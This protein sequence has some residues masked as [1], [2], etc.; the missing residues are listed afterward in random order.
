M[1]EDDKK[2]I[3]SMFSKVVK[4]VYDE[5]K[6]LSF[7]VFVEYVLVQVRFEG[8]LMGKEWIEGNI[9]NVGA[10]DSGVIFIE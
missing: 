2:L 3:G 6:D 8:G 4:K 10:F 5:K 9:F 7:V 1:V